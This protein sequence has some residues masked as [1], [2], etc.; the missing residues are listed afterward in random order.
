[1]KL[2]LMLV[3]VKLVLMLVAA[4]HCVLL[5]KVPTKWQLAVKNWS[6][7]DNMRMIGN[8]FTMN[9][10]VL[11]DL[12]RASFDWLSIG[13]LPRGRLVDGLSIGS[14]LDIVWFGPGG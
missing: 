14:V 3:A 8:A 7:A 5:A 13:V 2:V 9:I 12:S 4:D 6:W 1:M 10:P 11:L